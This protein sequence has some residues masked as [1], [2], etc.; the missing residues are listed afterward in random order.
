MLLPLVKYTATTCYNF[1]N[2][3]ALGAGVHK[4]I[5]KLNTD[6]RRNV[7]VDKLQY[8]LAGV[9]VAA[10]THG[11]GRPGTRR[12]RVPDASGDRC[13]GQGCGSKG[14]AVDETV[15]DVYCGDG[16][17][18]VAEGER[19]GLAR[20]DWDIVLV[21]VGIG[22]SRRSIVALKACGRVTWVCAAVGGWT[23]SV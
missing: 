22:S 6:R 16:D 11:R 21:K 23:V 4:D 19:V 13:R 7:A 12:K 2:I 17:N 9:Q 5:R 1:S 18:T 20:H 15:K 8:S 3:A 14:G 10:R